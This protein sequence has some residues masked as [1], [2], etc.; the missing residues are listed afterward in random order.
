MLGITGRAG[1]NARGFALTSA[2]ALA[3]LVAPTFAS[4]APPTP[5][6]YGTNN[7]EG[8]FRNILPPGQGQDVNTADI[9]S[10]LGSGQRPPHD[11]DQLSMYED[12]VHAA[13]GLNDAKLRDYFKDST[14]GVKA[15]DIERTYSPR[16][17]VTIVRDSGYGVPHIYGKSRA[18]A[19]F[20]IG[21]ATA[22]DR[23]FFIDVLRHSGRAQ[24]SSFAGG[25]EGNREMD[26]SVWA[27]TPYNESDL[28][29]QYDR[30]DDLYGQDGIQIQQDVQNYV[31]GINQYIAEAK[32]NPLK[33]PGEYALTNHPLGSDDWKPTDV[34]SVAS[35]VAGI[36]GKGGGDELTSAKTL[37]QAK[38]R[39][40][41]KAGKK[42]WEDFLS[43]DD[44]EA[45]STVHGKRFPYRTIPKHSKGKAVPSLKSLK[46]ADVLAARSGGG[47][48]PS[49]SEFP[50]AADL[51]EPLKETDAA[52]NALLVSG[53]ESKS[54]HPLAVFGPQI[55]YFSPQI[56][57]E[58]DVHAPAGPTGP[59]ID[60]RGGS[61]PGANL[62]VQI[63]HGRDYAW[64]ATS[65]GQD[66]VDTYA[67]KLC[68]PGGGKPTLHSDSYVY[69]GVCT[70]FETLTRQNSWTPSAADQT[71]AG[72]E[73]LTAQRSQLG[74]VTAHGRVKGKPYAFSRLRT[75]YFHEVDPSVLGFSAFNDPNKMSDPK[76]FMKSASKIDFTFN[77]FFINDKHIAYFNSG[78]N[79]KRPAGTDPRLPVKANFPWKGYD[80]NLHTYAREPQSKH[81]Q[82]VDQRYL[83]SWNNKEAP[84]YGAD[85]FSYTSVYRSQSLDE[86]IKP[87]IKGKRK[88]T[89]PKLA[90]AMED[91][92]TVDLRGSQVLPFAL[93]VIKHNKIRNP[94]IAKA[95][96]QLNRWTRSGA[97]RRDFDDNGTYDDAAAVRIMDA[98]WPRLIKAEFKPSLGKDL[99][100]TVGFHDDAP[101]P[102][103]SSYNS[104]TYGYAQKDLR[105]ALRKRV[106]GDYS[107]VYCG[108]GKFSRCR[109][110]MTHSL[111][112]ALKHTSDAELYPGN[113]DSACVDVGINDPQYCHDTVRHRATG[114]ITQP[115]IEW[116]NRPT[117]QQVVEIKGHDK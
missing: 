54:G 103:G 26:R 44:P 52:S 20:G 1:R 113:P 104:V 21:Y 89:L 42:V 19:M 47:E 83:T 88:T 25:S 55:S 58:Q 80:A 29:L 90:D 4:A 60:A 93:D 22:E 14:F 3:L 43:S 111:A 96:R 75:T 7:A 51:L 66:I 81:P 101:G 92:G 27:D 116:I 100:N 109:K 76:K 18:G 30:L 105:S 99:Y 71:A 56:F 48:T 34:I 68:E 40:G 86:R 63:G 11:S 74:I 114:A 97:H 2:C 95:V 37:L 85:G 65:A 32:I 39:F 28:Q 12:L 36:F 91:A 77:W 67:L 23:L 13:P 112:A 98:W 45:P 15:N 73:T 70:P 9:L 24:L 78:S 57:M 16:D 69:K 79:P 117:F 64:S 82:V 41:K 108:K 110:A 106:K 33:M 8:T 38:Q 102:V 62:Y 59:P 115:P 107:Q 53:K 61:F 87:L 35:L 46:S 84:G 17:D 50:D 72:T 49:G 5:D 31:A 94:K 6:P 10:F